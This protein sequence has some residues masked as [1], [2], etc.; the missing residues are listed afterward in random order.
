MS[1]SFFLFKGWLSPNLSG[2]IL[3]ILTNVSST[4]KVT[5]REEKRKKKC[6]YPTADSLRWR[7]QQLSYR[8]GIAPAGPFFLPSHLPGNFVM[9]STLAR[10]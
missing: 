3:R 7:K 2:Y 4:L 5:V 6:D 8:S 9:D 1:R 10:S